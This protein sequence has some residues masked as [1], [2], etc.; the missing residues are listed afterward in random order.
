MTRPASGCTH[1]EAPGDDHLTPPATPKTAQHAS[2]RRLALYR[3]QHPRS[4]P[5]HALENLSGGIG[6]SGERE[7]RQGGGV[8]VGTERAAMP[9]LWVGAA[10]EA[11]GDRD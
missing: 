10:L 11:Q 1:G 9:P 2:G 8:C 3:L 4:E 5:R 7:G 6:R